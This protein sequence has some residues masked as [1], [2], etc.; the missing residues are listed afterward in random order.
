MFGEFR[1]GMTE[2][3]SL[4]IGRTP[5]KSEDYKVTCPKKFSTASLPKETSQ[6]FPLTFH[7]LLQMHGGEHAK[8]LHHSLVLYRH[9]Y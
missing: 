8:E 9:H 1:R 3:T 4:S 5:V 2:R 6:S 7:K